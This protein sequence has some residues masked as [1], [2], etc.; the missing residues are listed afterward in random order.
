M[1]I[2]E[3]VRIN[4]SS[5]VVNRKFLQALSVVPLLYVERP[6]SAYHST[7]GRWPVDASVE[8]YLIGPA[9]RCEIAV[10]QTTRLDEVNLINIAQ[11]KRF[12]QKH[13]IINE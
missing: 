11:V 13:E 12:T 5:S 3:S 6:L 9:L 7:W 1:Y 8:I 2:S 10:I 4:G